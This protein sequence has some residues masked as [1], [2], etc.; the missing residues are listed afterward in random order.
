MRWILGAVALLAVAGPPGAAQD[1]L[2]GARYKVGDTFTQEVLVTRKS[3]FRVAGLDVEKWARYAITSSFTIIQI[4]PEGS[5]MAEQTILSGQLLDAD[6][7]MKEPITAALGKIKGTRLEVTVRAN[8][9]VAELKGLKDAVQVRTGPDVAV[10]Q[11]LRLWSLLDSDAWKELNGLTFFQP[12]Q[13]SPGDLPLKKWSRPTT[14][15]WGALG[16]WSGQTKYAL[17]GKQ[18]PAKPGLARY[19]YRHDLKYQAP[20]AGAD[21]TLPLKILKSDFKLV[22]AGGVIGY[23]PTVLKV[24]AAEEVFRVRG[25]VLASLAGIE[26]LIEL[27]EQQAFRVTVP[28]VAAPKPAR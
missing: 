27:E 20:N 14:H 3:L 5:L 8:G 16:S 13:P 28:S 11:S 6:P 18:A 7:D 19:E 23:N 2:P 10:G 1:V 25:A 9:E 26:V 17:V 15:D 4:D 12:E 22:S 21:G 24:A